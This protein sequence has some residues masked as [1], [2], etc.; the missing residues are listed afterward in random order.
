MSGFVDAIE[1]F[2]DRAADYLP[3]RVA[4]RFEGT[5]TSYAHFREQVRRAAQRTYRPGRTNPQTTWG[6]PMAEEEKAGTVS[7]TEFD[8][9]VALL[10]LVLALLVVASGWLVPGEPENALR[11][12]GCVILL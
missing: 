6:M 1:S 9:T 5:S 3:D 2:L 8:S 12:V 4:Y 11:G 7:R 10:L